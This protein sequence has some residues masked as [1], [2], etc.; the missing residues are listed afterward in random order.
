MNK[1]DISYV[2][3]DDPLLQQMGDFNLMESILALDKAVPFIRITEP[4]DKNLGMLMNMAAINIEKERDRRYLELQLRIF[5]RMMKTNHKENEN[6]ENGSVSTENGR[7]NG[8]PE[9]SEGDETK[10]STETK[11]ATVDR[12]NRESTE[13]KV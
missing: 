11:P 10:V 8:L 2:D 3:S 12:E 13:T 6:K 5:H 9:V 7:P 4:N 1:P